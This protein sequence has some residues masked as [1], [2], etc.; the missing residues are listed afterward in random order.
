MMEEH[1]DEDANL[2]WP[3][4]KVAHMMADP[5]LKGASSEPEAPT[6][7]QVRHM[8]TTPVKNKVQMRF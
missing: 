1:T 8:K 6:R 4:A 5:M 7:A 2:I 3:P